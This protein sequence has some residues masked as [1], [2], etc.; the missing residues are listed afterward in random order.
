ME[1]FI[2]KGNIWYLIIKF[3]LRTNFHDSII[4][5][6]WFTT[7]FTYKE[8]INKP[9]NWKSPNQNLGMRLN[10][11]PKFIVGMPKNDSWYSQ[12]FYGY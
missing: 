2:E 12:N 9:K 5:V 1:L 10:T 3:S 4:F 8:F 11:N 6:S 7:S